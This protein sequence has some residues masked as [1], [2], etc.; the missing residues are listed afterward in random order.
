MNSI[1]STHNPTLKLVRALIRDAKER[2]ETNLFVVEGFRLVKE[3]LASEIEVEKILVSAHPSKKARQLAESFESSEFLIE[4]VDS[5][6]FEEI[7]ATENSQGILAIAK[8]P[9]GLVKEMP[10]LILIPD[11]IRDPGNLGTLLRSGVAAGVELAL[12]PPETTDPFSPKA[13]RSGMGAHFS[14]PIQRVDWV[15]IKTVAKDYQVI[16][17]SADGEVSIWDTDLNS[18]TIIIIGGEAEGASKEAE[19]LANLRVNI[20]M[21]GKIESLNAGIAGSIILFEVLRQRSCVK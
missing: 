21:K 3:L 10:E 9:K 7:S 19:E 15:E 2:R 16:I 11:R 5:H 13:L 20:P 17:A 4:E 1:T 6:I 14:M 18:R 12:I 8:I